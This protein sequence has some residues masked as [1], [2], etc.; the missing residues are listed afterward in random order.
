MFLFFVFVFV[1]FV[2]SNCHHQ[3][4]QSVSSETICSQASPVALQS[5]IMSDQLG[6]DVFVFLSV[7]VSISV[8]VF[9]FLFHKFQLS[10]HCNW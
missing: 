5:V 4:Y 2:T 3:L 6:N 1:S 10:M 9:V 8:C 7:F